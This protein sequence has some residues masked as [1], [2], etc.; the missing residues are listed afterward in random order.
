MKKCI[1]YGAGTYG[2]VYAK[3]LE[4]EY[5]VQGFIDDNPVLIGQLINGIEVLGNKDFS[6]EYLKAN[7]NINMFVPI[8]DNNLRYK[9]MCMYNEMGFNTPSFIHAQAN[10]DNSVE[11]GNG[12]YVL[13]GTNIMPFTKISDYTMI[14]MGVNIAH[15]T[16]I[17]KG[18]F[19]SLG[20]NIGASMNIRQNAYVGI[21][22]TL[23]TGVKEVGANA[24]IGAGATVIR[25]VPENA[26]MIGSPAKVLK[27]QVIPDCD[28]F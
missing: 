9:L 24:L 22:A 17:E 15:H 14:S 2:Q 21:A 11:I 18:C 20:T 25:D 23:M 4:N 26:V 3:Y 19:F 10:I 6:I 7:P 13:P 28:L 16:L 12:V 27:Y 5:F 8:G 1:V